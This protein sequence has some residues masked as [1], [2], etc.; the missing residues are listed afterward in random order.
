MPQDLVN[1]LRNPTAVMV[2]GPRT[3]TRNSTKKVSGLMKF[4]AALMLGAAV[5]SP[6]NA[7]AN[8]QHHLQEDSVQ[9]VELVAHSSKTPMTLDQVKQM[10]EDGQTPDWFNI[11][12]E[13]RTWNNAK[14]GAGVSYDVPTWIMEGK[15]SNNSVIHDTW[16]DGAPAPISLG[17]GRAVEYDPAPQTKPELS[18]FKKYLIQR[19]AEKL[20]RD[21]ASRVDAKSFSLTKNEYNITRKVALDEQELDHASTEQLDYFS[22]R[23][24]RDIYVDLQAGHTVEN[25]SQRMMDACVHVNEMVEAGK[26]GSLRNAEYG[27]SALQTCQSETMASNIQTNGYQRIAAKVGFGVAALL[28]K[29]VAI[30]AFI[31]AGGAALQAGRVLTGRREDEASPGDPPK[32]TTVEPQ[33]FVGNTPTPQA[34]APAAMRPH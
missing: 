26:V 33:A 19:D 10:V 13:G 24:A 1:A 15:I 34:P 29:G 14:P 22:G 32:R 11:E 20:Q 16:E 8:T 12:V 18:S 31:F 27:S 28:L 21:I 4:G 3:E 9:K 5:L 7:L 30:G 6:F 2:A 25:P 23:L 17:D